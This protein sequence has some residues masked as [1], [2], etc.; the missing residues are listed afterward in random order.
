[1]VIVCGKAQESGSLPVTRSPLVF[2]NEGH[3][4]VRDECGKAAKTGEL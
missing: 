4:E 3:E 2:C 1:M